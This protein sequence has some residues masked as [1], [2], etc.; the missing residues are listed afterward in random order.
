MDTSW[1]CPA[2]GARNEM[3]ARLAILVESAK[4]GARVFAWGNRLIPCGGCGQGRTEEQIVKGGAV[5]TDGSG[6]GACF[7]ASASV[8]TP[9]GNRP[10]GEFRVGDSVL[11]AVD[12]TGPT[13]MRPVLAVIR[14]DS[15]RLWSVRMSGAAELVATSNHSV[16]T[17]RG[18]RRIDELSAGA[19]LAMPC[20]S[21]ADRWSAVLEVTP[22]LRREPVFN[23]LTACEHTFVV[24]GVLVHNFTR[25]RSLRAT[26]HRVVIDRR[27]VSER[28]GALSDARGSRAERWLIR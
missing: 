18:W 12:A 5:R 17:T 7:P 3:D 23:L 24:E 15:R 9:N 8:A 10:I 11:S 4:Q 13:V 21:A 26:W 14:H 28:P 2:C 27:S 22:T 25:L 6:G 19:R 1:K 16:L 20:R